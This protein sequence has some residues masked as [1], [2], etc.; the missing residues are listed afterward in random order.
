MEAACTLSG[1][2]LQCMGIVHF[3]LLN[4]CIMIKGFGLDQ[5]KLFIGL[6]ENYTTQSCKQ[7]H[8]SEKFDYCSHHKTAC[9]VKYG[10]RKKLLSIQLLTCT[11]AYFCTMPKAM[12]SYIRCTGFLADCCINVHKLGVF[13]SILLLKNKDQE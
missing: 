1:F 7:Y 2:E 3:H 9:Q 10:L 5:Q 12:A 13:N 8:I 6:I 11:S 4:V